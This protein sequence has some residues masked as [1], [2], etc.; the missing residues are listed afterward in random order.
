MI[1]YPTV[2]TTFS[3]MFYRAV[4][5]HYLTLKNIFPYVILFV[6]AK[7]LYFSVL[8]LDLAVTLDFIVYLVGTL[9]LTFLFSAALLMTDQAFKGQP[10]SLGVG[11]VVALRRLPQIYIV[12]FLYIIGIFITKYFA[13]F[14]MIAVGKLIDDPSA[15]HGAML[16]LTLAFV[17][18]FIAMFSFAIPLSVIEKKT[19]VRSFY[20]SM[21][22]SDKNK[23]GLF[24]LFFIGFWTSALL[25][26]VILL[27]K[28]AFVANYHLGAL[29]DFL[30]ICLVGPFILNLLLLIIN[31]GKVQLALEDM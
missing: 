19:I 30:V 3:Q 27:H 4:R 5:W 10:L 21:F 26:P 9:L 2:R 28:I 12:L 7:N 25:S 1:I 23:Y 14:L 31:D 6:I 11:L 22:V 18:A 15:V 29:V 17:A 24:V 20:E 8:A 13:K 16:F